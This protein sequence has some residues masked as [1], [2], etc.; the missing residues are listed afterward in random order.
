MLSHKLAQTLLPANDY[1]NNKGLCLSHLQTV[2]FNNLDINRN[3]QNFEADL[4]PNR[5]T[6]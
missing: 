4:D 2:F 3:I 6:L 1:L 5:L